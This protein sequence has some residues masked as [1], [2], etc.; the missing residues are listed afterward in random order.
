VAV[1]AYWS[2]HVRGTP[3][4]A[5][6]LVG[7]IVTLALVAVGA[8][9][10]VWLLW[11]M[12]LQNRSALAFDRSDL[13][14]FS[15][16]WWAYFVP[17]VINPWAGDVARDIWAAASVDEGLLEQQVTLG[18]GLVLLSIVA[19]G[20]W[21]LRRRTEH[22]LWV[23]PVLVAVALAALVCSL[24][25]ERVVLGVPTVR[26]SAWLY[27]LAPMFRA[28]ARFG[29]VVQLMTAL[30]GGVGL[31]VLR[32]V[33]PRRRFAGLAAMLLVLLTAAE[34][35]A[36]PGTLWRDVLPTSAHRWVVDQHAGTR[37]LDCVPPTLESSSVPWLTNDRIVVLGGKVGDC[38]ESHLPD[39][40]RALGFSHLIVRRSSATDHWFDL[41][42]P[43]AGLRTVQ[44]FDD[45]DIFAVEA[46][47]PVV[48]TGEVFGLLA[49]EA[50]DVR[51]WRW[52]GAAAAWE[53]IN[54]TMSSTSTTL[55]LN[56]ESFHMT[57]HLDVLLDGQLQQSVTVDTARQWYD[58]GPLMLSPGRHLVA[59]RAVEPP[60]I[61]DAVARNG[62]TRA[63]SVA[64]G[65][66]MWTTR[67]GT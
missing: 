27:E 67:G 20:R 18:A 4:A 23:V 6:S 50:D 30:L 3:A 60:T 45:A 17:P 16:K 66:W 56:L 41:H 59:F 2:S 35:T 40:L 65:A 1:A 7:T 29:V 28:Y 13:F 54:T 24:S 12:V 44:S 38:L 39:K 63:L 52:M 61:A 10:C 43:G 34:Y 8:L 19:I 22:R 46:A 48:Y 21:V 53:V 9:A 11:P 58:I 26:P 49:R 15:A 42:P 64:L 25:P 31:D 5:R 62:D 37:T 47:M 14:V 51:A 33:H 36:A 55:R 57:R 32:R